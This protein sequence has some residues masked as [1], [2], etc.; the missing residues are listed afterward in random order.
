M[1]D[2]D[3]RSLNKRSELMN[4]CW[5]YCL[6]RVESK[7]AK[8]KSIKMYTECARETGRITSASLEVQLRL[9]NEQQQ[10]CVNWLRRELMNQ[11]QRAAVIDE[12]NVLSM[13]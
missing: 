5:P 7:L 2:C 6:D 13:M 4:S 3:P 8:T 12:T 11:W 9:L 1:K 10:R